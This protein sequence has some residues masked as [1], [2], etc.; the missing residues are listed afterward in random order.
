VS[1]SYGFVIASP[2]IAPRPAIERELAEVGPIDVPDF[3]SGR[4][5]AGRVLL[6]LLLAAVA[7]AI[8][9]TILSYT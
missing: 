4:R 9:A 8:A 7:A 6:G 3:G 1:T 2:S 5:I